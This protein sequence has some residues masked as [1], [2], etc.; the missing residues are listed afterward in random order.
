MLASFSVLLSILCFPFELHFLNP[1]YV[2][3]ETTAMNTTIPIPME[4]KSTT[5]LLFALLEFSSA[6][7]IPAMNSVPDVGFNNIKD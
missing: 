5:I 2:I 3:M 1:K 4:T 6:S 7:V